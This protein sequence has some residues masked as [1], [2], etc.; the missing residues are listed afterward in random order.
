MKPISLHLGYPDLTHEPLLD[1]A[2][3]TRAT[4]IGM[5]LEKIDGALGDAALDS[6]AVKIA[7]AT[8]DY[9]QHN[10]MLRMEGDRLLRELSNLARLPILYNRFT[11]VSNAGLAVIDGLLNPYPVVASAGDRNPYY[12]L[13]PY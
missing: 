8:V 1:V 7:D 6:M 9:V 4:E 2:R 12:V 5:T 11:G 10:G 3:Q 13:S